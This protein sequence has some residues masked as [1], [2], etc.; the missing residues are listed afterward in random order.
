MRPASNLITVIMK[1][2]K[3]NRVFI[4]KIHNPSTGVYMFWYQV[5]GNKRI[6]KKGTQEQMAKAKIELI[7]KYKNENIKLGS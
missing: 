2:T 5:H 1:K 6:I 3:K 7:E 4:S